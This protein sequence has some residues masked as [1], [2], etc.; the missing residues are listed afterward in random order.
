MLSRSPF[1]YAANQVI[2]GKRF[3]LHGLL[4]EPKEQLAPVAG[5]PAIEPEREF[6]QVVVQMLMTYGSLMRPQKPAFQQRHHTMDPRQK[7]RGRL[8]LTPQDRHLMGIAL[9]RQA[10]IGVPTVGMN[11]TPGFHRRFHKRQQTIGRDIGH[12][13]QADS[14]DPWASSWAATT[15]N[16]LACV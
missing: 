6:I 4:D 3:R 14:P 13:L 11:Y 1:G 5:R 10:P 7:I 9:L 8:L 12:S 15:I 16:A 2:I